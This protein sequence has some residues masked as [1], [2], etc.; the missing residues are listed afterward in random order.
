M[1]RVA[2]TLMMGACTF[3]LLGGNAW[4]DFQSG[5]D[6]LV[7]YQNPDGGW[8]WEHG[9]LPPVTPSG[10]SPANTMGPIGLGLLNAY[11]HTTDATHLQAAVDGANYAIATTYPNLEARFG[12][13]D[14]YFFLRLSAVTGDTTYA[15]NAATEFFDALSA[16]TYGPS[17]LNTAGWISSVQA[18]RTGLWVNLRPWEFSTI[19]YTAGQIGNAGQQTD[20]E[21]AIIAGLGT[22]D[23]AAY[24]D[25]LG[26]AG[27]LYGLALDGT[28]I[29]STSVGDFGT[30]ADTTALAALLAGA[31]N[32]DGSWNWNSGLGAGNE[33][34]QVTAYA[35][36]A[37]LAA[38][39]AGFG[40]WDSQISQARNWLWSMQQPSGGFLSYPGGTENHEVEGE[41]LQA[42]PEPMTMMMLGCIG[43]GMA[44]ARKLRRK[45]KA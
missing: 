43:A 17:N 34:T 38:D 9:T 5:G 42:V 13:S 12:T 41:A 8:S 29:G 24:Y 30:V 4:A 25:Y 44:A 39:A 2:L 40:N 16:G 23:S 19:A 27:G 10:G 37:L 3:L 33:D 15:N 11:S 35:T 36:L 14:P 6:H 32:A 22:L 28:N 45:N 31:Q 18:G 21:N 20:F 26:L 1:R 7:D